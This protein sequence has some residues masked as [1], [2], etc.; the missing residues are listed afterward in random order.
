MVGWGM[1]AV[2][3]ININHSR[4]DGQ[5]GGKDPIEVPEIGVL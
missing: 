5:K 2:K 1:D 3:I 4:C